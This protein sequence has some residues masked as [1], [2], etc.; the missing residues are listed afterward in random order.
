[1]NL[2]RA[3]F[4]KSG[5]FSLN[6]EKGQGR[7]LPPLVAHLD[8]RPTDHRPTEPRPLTYRPT[9]QPTTDAKITDPADK[10]LFQRLD[11]SRIFI[12]QNTNTAG[13][14]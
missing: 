14:M 10:I 3:F 7:P 1:M 5:H 4:P 2:V 8:H 12:L 9:D 13:K 6:F 11:Q